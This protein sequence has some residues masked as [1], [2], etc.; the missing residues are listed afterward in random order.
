MKWWWGWRRE[1]G[2][3]EGC[4]PDAFKPLLGGLAFSAWSDHAGLCTTLDMCV[5]S[6]TGV[7]KQHGVWGSRLK[8]LCLDRCAQGGGLT[9]PTPCTPS[10]LV[11]WVSQVPWCPVKLESPM[12]PG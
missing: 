10:A 8:C 11:S 5:P 2:N 6:I 1:L 9:T 4:S 12:D 7:Q 3:H